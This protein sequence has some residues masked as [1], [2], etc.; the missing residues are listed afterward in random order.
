MP[1]SAPHACQAPGCPR[2]TRHGAFCD[3]HRR[4]RNQQ[5]MTDNP[6]HRFYGTARWRR[7]RA[8]FLSLNPLCVMCKAA[9]RFVTAVHVDHIVPRRVRPDLELD[10]TNC[11]ALCHSCHSRKTIRE[12]GP[13]GGSVSLEGKSRRSWPPYV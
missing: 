10:V 11:Q 13:V 1:T 2:T 6:E 12:R 5:R 4:A 3:E 9:G 7:F 8:W